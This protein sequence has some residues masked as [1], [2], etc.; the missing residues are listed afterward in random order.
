MQ[1]INCTRRQQLEQYF[2]TDSGRFYRIA[3]GILRHRED[4]L[5][6]VQNA[7]IRAI[8][9]SATLRDGSFLQSW[10][11]RILVNECYAMARKRCR[12]PLLADHNVFDTFEAGTTLR[13][14]E[15][16]E[17]AVTHALCLLSPQQRTLIILRYF[18]ELKLEDIAIATNQNLSTVK[19]RLYKTLRYLRSLMNKENEQ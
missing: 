17:D 1:T 7:M 8:Q 6:A 16:E 12:L 2:Q 11:Y 10:F 4:A 14:Q 9:K 3:Y 15:N 13:S 19:T 5:D 18:E